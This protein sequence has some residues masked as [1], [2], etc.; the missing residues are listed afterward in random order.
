MLDSA[1]MSNR[2]SLSR[3]SLI[4]LVGGSGIIVLAAALFSAHAEHDPKVLLLA[5]AIALLTI[6]FTAVL[7]SLIGKLHDTEHQHAAVERRYHEARRAA[8]DSRRRIIQLAHRDSL[9]GLPSRQHLQ[10]RLPR[11]LKR[12]AQKDRSIALVYID[13]DHFK[14]INESRGHKTGDALLRVIAN[15]LKHAVAS[16]DLVVRTGGDE[17]MVVAYDVGE[18]K[19]SESLA[20]RLMGVL[21]NPIGIDEVPLNITVSMG[22]SLYPE[23]GKE[24]EILLK[25]ADIAL[26]QAKDR[27][28]NNYQWFTADM[29]TRL[30]ERINLEQALRA[31]IGTEQLFVEYQ[32]V[33]DISTGIPQALEALARWQHPQMGLIPPGRFIPVAES[34]GTIVELGEYILRRVCRQVN[35]WQHAQLPLL[36]ISIN[37][38]S[39]QFS[40]G[41]LKQTVEQITSEYGVDPALLW[42][43]ITESAV[44]HDIEQH[45]GELHALRALGVRISVDDFGTGYSSLSYLKHLP[46]DALKVD[47]SFVRDMASD[48]NDA[49][50]VN[51]IIR[52]AKSLS[53][54]TVAE[55]V[56]TVEQLNRLR[57]LSCDAAQ[58]Y[59]FGRPASA[60]SCSEILTSLRPADTAHNDTVTRRVLRMVGR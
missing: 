38:S 57:A 42:L 17:F 24:P 51:A 50:I 49:A 34:S 53:L 39:Q 16:R 29:N 11:M 3:I 20:N 44:M 19:N 33:V 1:A 37:V 46:L 36:P 12:A 8:F 18:R 40:Q 56:E 7:L 14:N 55:G 45:L 58:G 10:W 9:T 25:H 43:E 28:R 23:D 52:M 60:Q 27:G 32:P 35:E 48:P 30:L 5:S 47:R 21:S 22:I 6:T 26:Y 2:K 54:K 13:V 41:K 31:A 15:R 4:V 59:Y